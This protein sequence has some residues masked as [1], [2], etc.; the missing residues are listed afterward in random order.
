MTIFLTLKDKVDLEQ[1]N[2]FEYNIPDLILLNKVKLPPKEINNLIEHT[3]EFNPKI[4]W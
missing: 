4:I 3:K 1:K 2:F